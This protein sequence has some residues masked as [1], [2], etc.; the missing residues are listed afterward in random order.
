MKKYI[1]N[2]EEYNVDQQLAGFEIADKTGNTVEFYG[3]D[4]KNIFFQFMNCVSYI[5]NNVDDQAVK[6]LKKA[7]NLG[8]YMSGL[9]RKFSFTKINKPLVTGK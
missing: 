5:Y 2:P 9:S 8:M 7:D 4:G 6:E 1:I 3:T